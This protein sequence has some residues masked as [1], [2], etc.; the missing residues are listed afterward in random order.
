MKRT[1]I[2][3]TNEGIQDEMTVADYDLMQ[4]SLRDKGFLET[5]AL[6]KA[7]IDSGNAVEIGP[8][9]GYLGLEWL[10]STENTRL[11]GIEISPAMINQAGTNRSEYGLDHRAEYIEGSALSI[12][13]P[14]KSA[15]CI[16]SNGSLHEWENPDKVLAEAYRILKPGGKLYI[17]DL[18]RNMSIFIASIMRLMTRG[19]AMK[20]GLM[21]SIRA[22]YTTDELE[23]ICES[24]VFGEFSI[25]ENAIGLE[26]I[27][28]KTIENG[29]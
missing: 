8:G 27:A 29:E 16:F 21:S 20:Q 17:S 24:S 2:I 6:I 10:K 1:R 12:P 19:K 15:D 13:L 28:V 22:A 25:S 5:K 4:R 9:P 3:E 7:G 18:K 23:V 11:T 14:D 26:L